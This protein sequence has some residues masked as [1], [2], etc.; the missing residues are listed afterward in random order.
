MPTPDRAAEPTN[1]PATPRPAPGSINLPWEEYKLLQDKLDRIGNF[2]FRVKALVLAAGGLLLT[3]SVITTL[4]VWGPTIAALLVVP[5]W[6]LEGY[7]IKLE[8]T[9]ILRLRTLEKELRRAQFYQLPKGTRSRQRSE[10]GPKIVEVTVRA[11]PKDRQSVPKT[12]N[13]W[14]L[15]V[16]PYAHIAFYPLALLFFLLCLLLQIFTTVRSR[17]TSV[18]PPPLP[19]SAA[20]AHP[21]PQAPRAARQVPQ[22]T[23]QHPPTSIGTNPTET[24]EP[25]EEAAQCDATWHRERNAEPEDSH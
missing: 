7:Y 17:S 9:F 24:D 3:G 1:H 16:A 13:R 6:M 8:H 21:N 12:L 4:G 2:R 23:P 22:P 18:S 20:M 11:F 19:P 25:T 10:L 15:V 5:F 14:Q